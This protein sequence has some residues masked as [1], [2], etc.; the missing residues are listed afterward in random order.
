MSPLANPLVGATALYPPPAAQP[1]GSA[2]AELTQY[3]GARTQLRLLAG[4]ALFLPFAATPPGVLALSIFVAHGGLT[5]YAV[6]LV[7]LCTAWLPAW[8]Y[9]VRLWERPVRARLAR[10][11]KSDAAVA[12]VSVNIAA[13]DIE[14]AWAAIRRAGLVVDY[15]R[16]L[17][18]VGMEALNS[19]IAVAQWAYRPRLDDFAFRDVV[20]QVF[21]CAGMRANVGGIEVNVPGD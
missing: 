7:S 18:H 2:R 8:A 6:G 4:A 19:N 13:T 16:T 17:G 12:R 5:A 20:C 1:F 10:R 11:T 14:A 21:R 3:E 15:T 9:K